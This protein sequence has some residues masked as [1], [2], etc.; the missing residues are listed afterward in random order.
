MIIGLVG[1][2]GSGKTEVGDFLG[3][4]GFVR[5]SLSKL[6]REEAARR[7][8]KTPTRRQL[9]DLGNSLREQFGG[10]ILVNWAFM[11]YTDPQKD[12]VIDGIR[13]P[14]EVIA[15]RNRGGHIIAITRKRPPSSSPDEEQ[16]RRRES[17]PSEPKY[18]QR[19][20][21]AIEMKDV[22]IQ[23]GGSK[24]DLFNKVKEVIDRWATDQS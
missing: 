3:S 21:D 10:A 2:S 20:H 17:D 1:Y 23:N 18:G 9:Q 24:Q 7:D 13:N 19:V 16:D 11:R 5:I 8:E 14:D 6:V 4:Q 15:V 12:L 22:E